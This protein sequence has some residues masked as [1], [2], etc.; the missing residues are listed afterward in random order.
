MTPSPSPE[1]QSEV[2]HDLLV[3][4]GSREAPHSNAE[5]R[6]TVDPLAEFYAAA[7]AEKDDSVSLTIH[8]S[9]SQLI[10]STF[11]QG[12]QAGPGEE[13]DP[14]AESDSEHGESMQVHIPK[15]VSIRF[16]GW[17]MSSL[18]VFPGMGL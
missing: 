6:T 9:R 13:S 14:G 5:L 17:S 18:S 3:R 2:P 8:C 7:R 1:R 12:P 15:R 11:V 16:I 4:M 10:G